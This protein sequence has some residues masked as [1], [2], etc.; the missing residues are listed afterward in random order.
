MSE[1]WLRKLRLTVQID[2][3]QPQALD[4]SDFHIYFHINQATTETPKAAEIY[5]YNISSNTMNLLCGPDNQKV[6]NQVVLEVAYGSDPFEIIFKGNVFQFRR[7]RDNP[8]DTW[9][10]ILAQSGGL[11]KKYAVVNKSLPAGTTINDVG[12][13]LI[14]ELG[15]YGIEMGNV[16]DMSNQRY[17]RGRVMFGSLDF[18]IKGLFEENNLEFDYSDDVFDAYPINQFLTFPLQIITAKTGM[19]GM[20]QLTSEGLRVTT[21]INPKFKKGGRVQ[22]DM[23]NLQTEGYDINY[24]GQGVDQPYKNPKLAT[25]AAGIFVIQSIEMVGDNRGTE[26]YSQLVCTGL[27]ATVPKSGISITAVE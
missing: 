6:N 21:L 16:P 13:A 10:C 8:T 18:K 27:N 5:I 11:V 12:Q 2:E 20:P 14:S 23:T 26:W 3:G 7:G 15:V 1:Q 17:P 19:I 25:N 22:V 24:G 9:L 4:L